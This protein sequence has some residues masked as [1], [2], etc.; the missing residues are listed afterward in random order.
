[1]GLPNRPSLLRDASRV[2]VTLGALV[3]SVQA[4]ERA[5]A[6][7]YDLSAG[8]A[9]AL[10]T[11]SR[12]GPLSVTNLGQHLYL[13]KST[14]SRLAKSLLKLGLARKR[15]SSSDDRKVILQVTEG[16]MRLSRRILNDLNEEYLDLL[17]SLELPV[18]KA[19]PAMLESL[20]QKL[21]SGPKPMDIQDSE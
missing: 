19:L 21:G 8:Q 20:V 6:G 10:L 15:P 9:I 14:A 3:R 16:G 12:E 17:G 13:E 11:L 5:R 1:M 18:R 4:R 2:Q 7:R